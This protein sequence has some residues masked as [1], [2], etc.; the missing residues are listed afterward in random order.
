[1]RLRGITVLV[2]EVPR[3]TAASY[4]L[5]NPEEVYAFLKYLVL[6]REGRS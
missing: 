3:P 6:R 5:R 1:M 4:Y 2:A